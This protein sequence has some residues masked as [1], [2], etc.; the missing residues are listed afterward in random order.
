MTATKPPEVSFDGATE[1]ALP[2]TSNWRAIAAASAGNALEFYDL[3]IFGYFAIVIG[4]QFFPTGDEWSS[5]MLSAGTFG[6]S[7]I[8]RPLGSVLLGA[9]ADHA[10]RRAA[11]TVSITLMMIG[12]AI[13]AFVPNYA[14]IGLWAPAIVVAARLLQGLSTG[15]E[16][17]AATAFMV[18]HATGGQR[19]FNASWQATTQGLATVLA[20]GVSALITYVL[21]QEEVNDWAWR[22]PFCFGLL[23]GPVGLY[24]RRY[25]PETPDFV[26]E[27]ASQLRAKAVS[28]PLREVF[29]NNL[30]ELLLGAGLVIAMT[31]F[32][33]VQKVYMP[34]YAIKQ[35]NIPESASF[36]GA[37][38]TGLTVMIA[39]PLAGKLCGR[40]GTLPVYGIAA[41]LIALTT[42]PMFMVLVARPT[43]STLLAVQAFVG[44]LLGAILAPLPGILAAIFP[45]RTRG[46]GLA[47]SYNV[48]VTIFGGFA[49]LI[50]TWLIGVTGL[51]TSPSF[52][53]LAA[54]LIS[55]AALWSL[56]LRQRRSLAPVSVTGTED[57]RHRSPQHAADVPASDIAA[58]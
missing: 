10:G 44:I 45:T 48:S 11:L 20:A 51:K 33:Y 3:L 31:G 29:A 40:I 24:I 38:V 7:Y 12:S 58:G 34:T 52:Y 27:K 55:L 35:L 39:S 23:I 1:V 21:P 37:M 6:I 30:P 2:R 22:I 8:M 41:G 46:T 43:L 14:A 17:G 50:V 5:L 18:E 32:N 4:N 16:F 13:I 47:L 28:S 56:A 19:S 26:E 15:G 57:H 53:V 36:L 49:P 42:Y 54:S 9:Y 25:T